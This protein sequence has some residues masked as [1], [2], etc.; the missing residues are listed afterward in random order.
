[1]EKWEDCVAETNKVFDQGGVLTDMTGFT[2]GNWVTYTNPEIE[3]MFGGRTQAGNQNDYYP[4]PK[5][6]DMF[7]ATNDIRRKYGFFISGGTLLPNKYPNTSTNTLYQGIRTAEAILNRAEAY[8]QLGKLPEALKDLN[9]LRRTRIIGYTD[10]SIGDKVALLQKVRDE[11]RKEF[12]MEGFRWFDLRRYGM[13]EIHH[14]YQRELGEAILNYTLTAKDAMYTL[15]FPTVL[16]MRNP[17]LIQNTSGNMP[18]R[19]GQ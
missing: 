19:V 18:D 9:D 2:A 12:Y 14:R 4:D 15:P 6:I 16:L 13:P 3:W 17:L 10:E 8:V 11:R 5:F 1:M 7:D